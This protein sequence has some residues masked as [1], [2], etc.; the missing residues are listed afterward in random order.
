LVSLIGVIFCLGGGSGERIRGRLSCCLGICC[1]DTSGSAEGV[2]PRHPVFADLELGRQGTVVFEPLPQT[3]SCM[4]ED[5]ERPAGEGVVSRSNLRFTDTLGHGWFGWVVCGNLANTGKV[6]VKILK[7]DSRPEDFDR[8]KEEHHTWAS[9]S[10]PH[11]TN[12]LGHCFNSFPMLSVMEWAEHFSAKT[13]LLQLEDHE[14]TLDLLLQLSLD[15]CCGLAAIHS[16]ELAV[17]DLAARNC[18]LTEQ[19]VLKVGDYGLGRAAYP[20]DY[21]PLMRESVPLRWISPRQLSREDHHTLPKYHRAKLEDNLW[22]LP[23]VIWELVNKCKQPFTSL[24]NND[25]IELLLRGEVGEHFT[26]PP[27]G[28]GLKGRAVLA[29]ATLGLV[30]D[31][32]TRPSAGTMEGKLR[33]VSQASSSEIGNIL[34][35]I[36]ENAGFR[37][38]DIS[39]INM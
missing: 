20:A 38:V 39:D 16:K 13:F 36:Q 8:F 5:T 35:A 14:A 17:P 21:W 7:E 37:D 23:I 18:L 2:D 6:I 24:S 33:L 10:H 12:I 28:T 29:V 4:T 32:E 19:F 9:V 11:V 3:L 27:P 26:Q 31:P 30:R 1:C 22:S 15:L 25:V 34:V